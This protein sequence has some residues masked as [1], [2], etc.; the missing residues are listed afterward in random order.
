MLLDEDRACLPW[1]GPAK[2]RVTRVCA[3]ISEMTRRNQIQMDQE[4]LVARL[5]RTMIGWANYFCL[6]QS[7]KPI[8]RWNDMPASG[9]VSGCAPNI[10]YRGR[11]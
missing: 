6:G 1:H 5:N 7:A 9:C 4:A 3:T 2:K 11:R 10:R 8:E